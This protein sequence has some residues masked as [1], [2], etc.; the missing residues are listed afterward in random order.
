VISCLEFVGTV[1]PTK[2][3]VGDEFVCMFSTSDK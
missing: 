1:M 2:L 3:V